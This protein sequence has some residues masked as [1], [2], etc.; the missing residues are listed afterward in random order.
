[1]IHYD[2]EADSSD[3][4]LGDEDKAYYWIRE[5]ILT[6]RLL[7]GTRLNERKLAEQLGVGR[8]A[9]RRAIR[10]IELG[11]MASSGG[12]RTSA[13]VVTWSRHDLNEVFDLRAMLEGKVA[14]L[15]A[16]RM[17]D[18]EIAALE[19]LCVTMEA[20]FADEAT[21]RAARLERA[22]ISN[23]RFHAALLEGAGSARLSVMLQQLSNTPYVFRTYRC[24]EDA[25]VRRSMGHHRDIVLAIKARDADWAAT[26]MRSHVLASRAN[27]L[28]RAA[29]PDQAEDKTRLSRRR[30]SVG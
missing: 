15:A 1:M 29:H 16:Q 19:D 4:S 20:E 14:S 2:K 10:R 8:F 21:E 12:P 26:A 23:T 17:D 24:F 7:S 6:G 9:V 28:A 22:S 11:G 25:E 27:L 5:A 3:P 30:G 18:G 13:Y